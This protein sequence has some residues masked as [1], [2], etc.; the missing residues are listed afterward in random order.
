MAVTGSRALMRAALVLVLVA[1]AAAQGTKQTAAAK[2]S[3]TLSGKVCAKSDPACVRCTKSSRS[4]KCL[5]CSSG[6]E[7][8]DKGRCVCPAG[9]GV[10]SRGSSGKKGSGSTA[11]HGSK[12]GSGG[13]SCTE[14]PE[15][16][17][18]PQAK[19]IASAKCIKCPTGTTTRGETGS[20][21]CFVEPGYYFDPSQP[22]G[23]QVIICPGESF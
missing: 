12:G 17:Y 20:I 10:L 4:F 11:A 3:K 2:G 5:A 8:N 9:S 15:D 16:T 13:R 6:A 23:E 14:C 21:T 18:A 22:D 1:A 7:L 19:P